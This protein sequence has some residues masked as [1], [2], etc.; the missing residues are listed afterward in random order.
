MANP[1]YSPEL[2]FAPTFNWGGRTYGQNDR[3]AFA[4]LLAKRG[5]SLARW[6]AAHPN[7]AKV[8][9][10]AEQAVYSAVAP[11]LSAIAFE[12]KRTAE[13]NARMLRDLGQFTAALAPYLSRVGPDIRNTY[14][15]GAAGIQAAG[16]GYGSVL[17]QQ[18]AAL[19]GGANE[20]LNAIGAPSGQQVQGGDAGGVLA[21][22]AG[23]IPSVMMQQQ[24]AGLGAAADQLPYT[25]SLESQIQGKHMLD[26]AQQDDQGFSQKVLEIMQQIPG[27]RTQAANA[28]AKQGLDAAK[29]AQSQAKFESDQHYKNAMLALYQGD[30]KRYASELKLA[31]QKAD[32][33][34]NATMGLD[35]AGN[36][37]PGYHLEGGQVVK[38]GWKLGPNGI[39]K[40]VPTPKSGTKGAALTPN[41]R[42]SN[43]NTVLGKEK[44]ITKTDLPALAKQTGYAALLKQPNPAPKEVARLQKSMAR[45][46][47]VRYAPLA[48]TPEAKRAL[49]SMIA[50]LVKAYKPSAGG[51]LLEGLTS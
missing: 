32:V 21:G 40:K 4:A 29:F 26:Q 5:Q 46:L 42:A 3:S 38:D 45:A 19:A 16:T 22:L 23:W 41:A 25:S 30:R 39:P 43:M 28:A 34:A 27:L 12:R 17:N 8:F 47:W 20:T 37:K 31:Q 51:G 33:A 49:R 2:G 50:R 36:P 7:A 15:Q 44:D 24:G 35:A 9:D 13:N 6:A 1:L 48:A 14:G 10:P 18:Q 11:Q